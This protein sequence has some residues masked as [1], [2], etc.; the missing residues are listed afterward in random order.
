[1]ATPFTFSH[2]VGRWVFALVLVFATYNPSGYSYLDW[3]LAKSAD[4]SPIL[5][6]VGL[7]LL[8]GWIVYLRA[9]FMSLGWLGIVLSGALLA[10]FVWLLVDVGLLSLQSVSAFSWVVLVLVSL[11]L[12]V[13]MSW[14]HIR[15]R[16]SGQVDTDDL[17]DGRG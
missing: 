14:S 6:I 10:C 17:E 3:L 12:A 15:R 1:M 13:G 7:V 4:I 5:V 11:L 9:S 8:I 16:L 2:F